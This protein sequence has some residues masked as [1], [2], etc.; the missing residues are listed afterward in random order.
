M[1]FKNKIPL[2]TPYLPYYSNLLIISYLKYGK[3]M[4]CYGK[5]GNCFLYEK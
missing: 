4:E 5:Y 3:C 1:N 2:K